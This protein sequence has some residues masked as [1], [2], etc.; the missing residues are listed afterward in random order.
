MLQEYGLFN[1]TYVSFILLLVLYR[2]G[3]Q[4]A[5]K[6]PELHGYVNKW[7]VTDMIRLEL[8]YTSGRARFVD[9]YTTG[10]VSRR[11]DREKQ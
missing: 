7:P 8:K 5:E 11:R 6:F 1:I 9:K 10:Q 4:T 3:L 2:L